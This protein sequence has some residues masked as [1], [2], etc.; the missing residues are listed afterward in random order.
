NLLS[1]AP[2][3]SYVLREAHF[4]GHLG[5]DCLRALQGLAGVGNNAVATAL[6]HQANQ[7]YKSAVLLRLEMLE[8]QFRGQLGNR[9]GLNDIRAYLG[10]SGSTRSVRH[11]LE[12]F[13]NVAQ[14]ISDTAQQITA[15][16]SVACYHLIVG[17]RDRHDSQLEAVER[18]S[19]LSR[20]FWDLLRHQ[21]VTQPGVGHYRVIQRRRISEHM[22]AILSR[23][24][25]IP[26][27]I[28]IVST[29]RYTTKLKDWELK[30]LNNFDSLIP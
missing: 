15:M 1:Q 6:V 25:L 29:D 19:S 9:A 23:R 20:Q 24:D 22:L 8:S 11:Q 3:E 21:L 7:H 30:I 14:A 5:N 12:L 16:L 10:T 18:L 13:Q 2:S 4:H 27:T 26:S 17:L 28:P